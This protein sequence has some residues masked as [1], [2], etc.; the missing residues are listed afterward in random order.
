MVASILIT[1]CK[2]DEKEENQPLPN[3]NPVVSSIVIHPDTVEV[4]GTATITVTASDPDGDAL[5]YLY[6]PSGG[7]ISGNGATATWTVPAVAGSYSVIVTVSDGKGGVASTDRELTVTQPLN[8]NPVISSVVVNPNTVAVNGT[9]TI[10]VTASDPDGDA[11]TYTYT[12]SGGSVT[13]NGATAT[14]TAPSTAGSYSVTVSVSDGKGG[15][16]SSNGALNVTALATQIIG[17]AFFPAGVSGDLSNSKVSIYTSLQNWQLN[18]PV[19]F[20]SSTGSGASVSFT[21]TNV[22]PGNYYLDVWKDCDNTATWTAGDFVGWYGSGGIGSI[23]LTEFSIAQG[24][25]K[26]FSIQ[27]YIL[28]KGHTRKYW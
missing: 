26:T 19:K 20:T 22:L 3:R 24:Q 5:S 2:K 23:S 14:W 11:L 18:I 28:A 6:T 13:P 25:T 9:A 12:L 10:T 15:T 17:I 27:M 21:M 16:A 1:A 4:N 8:H 7:D